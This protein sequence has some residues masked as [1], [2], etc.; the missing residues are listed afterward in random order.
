MTIPRP[1][2]NEYGPFYATYV[3]QTEGT[4][5]SAQMA[6]AY[7]EWQSLLS[8]LTEAQWNFRY[9]QDK[10]TIKELVLHV[11][12]SERVY[13]YRALC[14]A[15]GDT[16]PLPG[17]DENHYAKTGRASSRTGR[18]LLDELRNVRAATM[19]LFENVSD[20]LWM[21]NG[22]AN[23]L[24]MS[25]RAQAYVLLGHFKHHLNILKE[26]YLNALR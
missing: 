20:G 13:A 6:A 21:Q 2:V 7:D 11:I 15:R 22:V 8:P 25:L 24:P 18:S 4:D 12:D 19:A 1:E 3:R 26:R 23:G 17:F 9:G 10:W 14:F 16:T 5:W